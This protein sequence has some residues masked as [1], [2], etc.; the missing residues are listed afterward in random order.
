MIEL[1]QK[2]FADPSRWWGRGEEWYCQELHVDN[3]IVP[4]AYL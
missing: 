2:K 3:I 4:Y 1:F